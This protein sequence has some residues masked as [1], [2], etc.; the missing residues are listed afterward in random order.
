MKQ[1]KVHFRAVNVQGVRRGLS[2]EP[3]FWSALDSLS[4]KENISSGALVGKIIN[5]AGQDSKNVSSDVRSYLL[6]SIISERDKF[7]KKLSITNA[8]RIVGACPTPCFILSA[9]KRIL[10]YNRA[11][12]EFLQN[13]FTQSDKNNLMNSM[14][15]SLDTSIST[16]VE[17]LQSDAFPNIK[18]PFSIIIANKSIKGTLMMVDAPV[19]STTAVIAYILK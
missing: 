7:E 10:S 4:L 6:K 18:C 14:T 1:K 2:L 9:D 3:V 16:L 15:L 17:K 5:K 11:F 19:S 13:R 8:A 12:V